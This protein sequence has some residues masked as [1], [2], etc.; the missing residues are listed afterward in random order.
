MA[1]GGVGGRGVAVMGGGALVGIGVGA[2][3]GVGVGPVVGR[4]VALEVTV[5]VGPSRSARFPFAAA[6]N[7]TCHEP[8]GRVVDTANVPFED[9]PETTLIGSVRPATEAVTLAAAPSYSTLKV[10]VVDGVPF[11]GDTV[12]FDSVFLAPRAGTA[13][14]RRSVTAKSGARSHRRAMMSK[15]R[16]LRRRRPEAG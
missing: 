12:G 13:N 8:T 7:I 6:V 9:V 5:T 10:K 3:G 2:G 4:G 14:M 1:G 15:D 11:G 16:G